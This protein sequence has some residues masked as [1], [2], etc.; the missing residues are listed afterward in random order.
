MNMVHLKSVKKKFKL[1]YISNSYKFLPF[2][3]ILGL[4][5][6]WSGCYFGYNDKTKRNKEFSPNMYNSIP[7]EPFVQTVEDTTA[8]NPIFPDGLNAQPAPHGTVPRD[9]WYVSEAYTPYPFSNTNEGYDSAGQFLTSPLAD[10]SV[11]GINCSQET[12]NRGKRIF[13]VYC[14]MCHGAN[15]DGKGNLVTSGVFGNVPSYKDPNTLKFLPVGKMFHTLTYGKG[16]MGSYA[17]QLTPRERWEVICYIQH[18][19]QED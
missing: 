17:S 11:Q 1:M 10:T 8:R 3:V 18:F 13:E 4:S 6:V 16:I 12:F 5:V 19:Q 15:G 7:L 9:S 2:W 14:I